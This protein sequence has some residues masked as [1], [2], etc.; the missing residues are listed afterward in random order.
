MKYKEILIIKSFWEIIESFESFLRDY[1]ENYYQKII[2]LL[3]KS[4]NFVIL[5][6]KCRSIGK[7]SKFSISEEPYFLRSMDRS[8][9]SRSKIT[10]YFLYFLGKWLKKNNF[11]IE[12]V[13]I[14]RWFKLK[15]VIVN[16]W[17]RILTKEADCSGIIEEFHK[18][19][20]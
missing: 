18:N 1:R 17:V 20:E 11:W 2:F 12:E 16:S 6:Q 8:T 14:A 4:S 7:S 9:S 19:N 13:V 10:V 15:T 3:L 5:F